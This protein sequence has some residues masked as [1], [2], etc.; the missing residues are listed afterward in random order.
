MSIWETL[1]FQMCIIHSVFC[2]DPRG[3]AMRLYGEKRALPGRLDDFTKAAKSY[4]IRHAGNQPKEGAFD[5]MLE[6]VRRYADRRNEVAHGI[7]TPISNITFFR[8]YL[9]NKKQTLPE[10]AVIAPYHATRM[11]ASDGLPR[12]AYTSTSMAT[13]QK[14]MES[15]LL[16]LQDYERAL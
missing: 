14:K 7:V 15:L 9:R 16:R 2:G 4:F 8:R 13:L 12:Y 10:Y 11:H 3:N 5:E 1:E 6:E